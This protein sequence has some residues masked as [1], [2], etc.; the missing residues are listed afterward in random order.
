MVGAVTSASNSIS[1]VSSSS[2]S[3]SAAIEA[4]LSAKRAE[5][6][7]AKTEEDK[8]KINNEIS[9]LTAQLSALKATEKQDA[10][11]TQKALPRRGEGTTVNVTSAEKA[12]PESKVPSA[13]MDVLMKMRPS[14]GVAESDEEGP[15]DLSTLYSDMDA[16]DDGKVTKNEFVSASA[17]H[18]SEDDASELFAAIDSQNTGSITEEQLAAKM[19]PA[20]GPP[21]GPPPEMAG[22]TNGFFPQSLTTDATT[23]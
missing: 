9:K 19:P 8:T 17:D 14:G 23:A 6:A 7:E 2:K 11:Q 21:M 22:M 5:L 15:R 16:D 1:S 20:G 13:V 10:T 3:G 12:A 4:Q 18:M